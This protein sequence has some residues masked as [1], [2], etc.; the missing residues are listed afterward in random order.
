MLSRKCPNLALTPRPGDHDMS[1]EMKTRCEKCGEALPTDSESYICSHECTFCPTCTTHGQNTCPHCGGELTRRPRRKNAT[2]WT[3]DQYHP[4]FGKRPWL[5]WVVSFG[6]WTFVALASTVTIYQL[7]RS[8]GAAPRFINII[9]LQFSQVLT[10]A[11]LSPFVF[12]LAISLPVQRE[13]WVSRS[14]LYLA[15]GVAFTVAHITLRGITPYAF[16]D[17]KAHAWVSA[18]WDTQAHVFNVQWHVFE[19]LFL[20]NIVDDITGTYVPIILI[21][22]A[23]SYYRRLR[24]REFRAAQLEG[25]LA[26]AHLQA[27]KS[28]LQPHFLFNTLHSISALMHT[29]VQAA[30]KMMS[31]LS[32]LLR[33][34][35]ANTGLQVTTLKREL[36]FLNGYLAI[37]RIRFGDRLRVVMKVS[38]DTLDAHVP[39]LILQPLVENAIRHGASKRS[40][41]GEVLIAVSHDWRHLYLRVQ[42]NGPGLSEQPPKR[43][44][45]LEATQ[46]RLQTLYGDN[47]SIEVRSA[48]VG[49]VEVFIRIPFSVP[50]VHN[51]E[52]VFESPRSS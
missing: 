49:G 19:N 23:V 11:P 16:W 30:D 38:P 17:T 10:Y 24:E 34:S 25:Q 28:Q 1:L 2:G 39:H 29:D 9:G 32:D 22:H 47:Q 27:L 36:E 48:P 50:A 40:A 45:G 3:G 41:E 46:E 26:K 13:N 37:E 52:P 7:Y 15:G 44:L 14:L 21:A 51:H 31:R 12:A 20:T 33:L 8:T 6:V 18:I 42:D 4:L 43:G 5:I 35:L